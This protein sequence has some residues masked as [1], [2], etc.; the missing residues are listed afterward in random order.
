MKRKIVPILYVILLY[1][2]PAMVFI[3]NTFDFN[4]Q[5]YFPFVLAGYFINIYHAFCPYSQKAW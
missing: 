1:V 5:M 2:F 4:P 3:F